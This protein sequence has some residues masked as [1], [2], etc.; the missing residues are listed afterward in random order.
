MKSEKR[1]T[2]QEASLLRKWQD[3]FRVRHSGRIKASSFANFPQADFKS[4]SSV[5]FRLGRYTGVERLRHRPYD[6][7]PTNTSARGIENRNAKVLS[8]SCSWRIWGAGVQ[9][10]EVRL[11]AGIN[12]SVIA[13]VESEEWE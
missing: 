7:L 8:R 11:A 12:A 13:R 5:K 10:R 9:T 3:F 2:A 4:V 6:G 1:C